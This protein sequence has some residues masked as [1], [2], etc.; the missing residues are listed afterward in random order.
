MRAIAAPAAAAAFLA[1]AGCNLAP[2]Y[3]PPKT[4]ATPAFKEAVS[5]GPAGQGWKVAAPNDA[6]IRGNWW[7]MYQDPALNDLEA[8]VAISN[9]TILA[10]EAN[11][12]A[13]HALV[14]EAQAQLYP[15]LTLDPSVTRSKSS[16]ALAGSGS[17]VAG[18]T[19]TGIGNGTGTGTTTGS[20]AGSS[21]TTAQTRNIF[22]FPLEA[23]YQIDL[24]GSIRNTVAVNRYAA[25]ASAA[26]LA[27][28]LLS[29]HSLLAQ[30]YFQLRVADEQRRIL[31]STVADY[32]VS[33]HLAHTLVAS[34]V[35][36]D[37]DVA[38][39]ETQL[40]S[41]TAQATD[42]GVARAQYEHAIAVLTGVSPARFSIPYKHFTQS[43]P[44][45]PVGVPSDLLERRPDI[46]SAERQVAQT[47]A[48]IGVA[49]AAYFPSLTLSGS[50]GYES[51]TL[52][53]LFDFPNRFW[54]VGPTLAQAL[55]DGGARRAAVAQARALNDS[56]VATYRQTVLSAFQSVEDDLAALRILSQELLQ[57][58]RATVAAKRAVELTIVLYRYGVDGYAAV[59]VAQ[60]AFLSARENELQIQLRELTA[61]VALIND[62]GGG[63][64]TAGRNQTER[65]AQ[66]PADTGS[67][68]QIPAEY[69]GP[70]TPNPPPMPPGEIHPD[71][72]L[73]QDDEVMAPEPPTGK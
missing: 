14:L 70:A 2:R 32:Q 50:A 57:A 63:W 33:L 67:L 69:S 34:G 58:H 8:R 56:Q 24:W 17:G 38:T 59:I 4:D 61:S 1:L 23:S 25:Q 11:Y 19:N 55:F 41:A 53:S 12:R 7:E 48:Q 22:T 28:A 31:E 51:T 13:A 9:Q 66:H 54:S 36:S 30:D 60:N 26:Q 21:S 6:E 3:E 47:N 18:G 65:L 16:A 44:I 35:D 43:L 15:S 64:S 71:E 29:T 49:R 5:G 42:V 45:I 52:G 62:L 37:A 39:A 40:E 46:A 27:N 20:A 72:L 10:A 68:P 73:R